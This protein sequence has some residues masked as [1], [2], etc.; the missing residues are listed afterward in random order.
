MAVVERAF[1]GA[2]SG[3]KTGLFEA[4]NHGTLLL[5]EISELPFSAQAKLLSAIQEK[6]ILPFG[7][8]APVKIDVKIVAAT[9]KDLTKLIE[10]NEFRAD[11]YYRLNI[12]ELDH[13]ATASAQKG[14]YTSGHLFS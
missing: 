13:P 2:K 8:T 9:N 1:T 4:A 10:S 5:D 6:E 11:L 3:G 12:F 14:Y 7:A